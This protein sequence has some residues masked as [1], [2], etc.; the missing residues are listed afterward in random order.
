MGYEWNRLER[1]F[2]IERIIFSWVSEEEIPKLFGK[3]RV[4]PWLLVFNFG[5]G[6][7]G[8]LLE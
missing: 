8:G 3:C 4:L 2:L 1:R 7:G 6:F 5:K